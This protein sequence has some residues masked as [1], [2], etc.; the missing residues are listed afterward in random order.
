MTSAEHLSVDVQE[1]KCWKCIKSGGFFLRLESQLFAN[2]CVNALSWFYRH[3][4]EQMNILNNIR[5]SWIGFEKGGKKVCCWPRSHIY[6]KLVGLPPVG[7]SMVGISQVSRLQCLSGS[8]ASV[9]KAYY[10]MA[11]DN[12]KRERYKEVQMKGQSPGVGYRTG[13]WIW[14]AL[15][16]MS[17]LL[18]KTSLPLLTSLPAPL[19]CFGPIALIF[20]QSRTNLSLSFSLFKFELYLEA[21]T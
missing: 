14:I 17:S 12:K 18:E 7:V 16:P 3:T 2:D 1:T 9:Y 11:V 19:F 10:E 8:D 20:L 6:F 13:R 4:T 15:L 21:L 5:H